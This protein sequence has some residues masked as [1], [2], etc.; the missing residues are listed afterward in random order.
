M[1][2]NFKEINSGAESWLCS[3]DMRNILPG[4]F[5]YLPHKEMGAISQTCKKIYL[6]A[7]GILLERHGEAIR[8]GWLEV[9]KLVKNK[10]VIPNEL[11]LETQNLTSPFK[12]LLDTRY[13][14][15]H[16]WF[17]NIFSEFMNDRLQ[18]PED[19]GVKA[20][21]VVECLSILAAIKT[22]QD[23]LSLS[24]EQC[25]FYE[26]MKFNSCAKN[27]GLETFILHFT[28]PIFKEDN[29]PRACGTLLKRIGELTNVKHLGVYLEGDEEYIKD[30][31]PIFCLEARRW[32]MIKNLKL[33]I[34]NLI[35]QDSVKSILCQSIIGLVNNR[36]EPLEKINLRG[37]KKIMDD[38]RLVLECLRNKCK[39]TTTQIDLT[40]YRKINE[41]F[42]TGT[43]E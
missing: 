21:D 28:N 31:F 25:T 2:I 34:N 41:K 6:I 39:D 8:N 18:N 19:V 14:L 7:H 16:R 30:Y 20:S 3:S 9:Y 13:E 29:N 36:K 12:R 11:V 4:I 23:Y 40:S 33:Q 22:P 37:E 15:N 17:L 32:N 26:L 24:G 43:I 42:A 35:T 38:L 27:K 1:N 5:Y 10:S